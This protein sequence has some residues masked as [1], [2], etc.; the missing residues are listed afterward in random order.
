MARNH[1]FPCKANGVDILGKS[2]SDASDSVFHE[3]R[4]TRP[5]AAKKDEAETALHRY[6][7]TVNLSLMCCASAR[8]EQ[9]MPRLKKA[10]KKA[11]SLVYEA[12]VVQI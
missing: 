9:N 5:A 1:F 10:L 4:S 6:L 3:V 2:N 11:K 8:L 7:T 12:N